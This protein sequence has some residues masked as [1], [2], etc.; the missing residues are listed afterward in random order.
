MIMTSRSIAHRI[1]CE[2]LI[3]HTP[4]HIAINRILYSEN[5]LDNRDKHQALRMVE[6]TLERLDTLDHFISAFSKLPLNKIKKPVLIALRLGAYQVFYMDSIPDFSAVNETVK[7]VRKLGFNGIE[8]FANA[9]MRKMAQ[10]KSVLLEQIRDIPYLYYS[11]PKW[12]FNSFVRDYG[13]EKAREMAAALLRDPDVTLRVNLSKISSSDFMKLLDDSGVSYIKGGFH[14][15]C[16]KVTDGTA[17]FDIPGYKEGL[18]CVQDESSSFVAYKAGIDK[19]D[20]VLDLC[21]APGGKTMHCLDI[22]AAQKGNGRVV[23]CDISED[24]VSKIRENI[25]RTGFE[26]SEILINDATVFNQAFEDGFDVVICD[27]PCSGIGI[28]A[29]KPDI[30]YNMT[31]KQQKELIPLQRQIITNAVRY[32]R[33]GGTLMYSTC[34]VNRAENEENAHFIENELGLSLIEMRQI[35]P[36]ENGADGFFFAKFKH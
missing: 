19:D 21:A 18:F 36:G 33:K 15:F 20:R 35:M 22:L 23:S 14:D 13:E 2:V 34:T 26:H 29:K 25:Q 7:L 32:V 4:S 16:L 6:G 1:L 11:L 8:G 31:E 5:E 28:I 10:N 27:V 3:D 30:K 9:I 12:I 17:V 24:K